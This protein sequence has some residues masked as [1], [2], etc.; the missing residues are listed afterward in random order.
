MQVVQG[1]TSSNQDV[2]AASDKTV[3]SFQQESVFLQIEYE[4]LMERER[5]VQREMEQITN[6][7]E[8][9][10]EQTKGSSPEKMQKL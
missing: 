3:D 8:Q 1:K 5:Q 2:M 6:I 7:I 10:Q 9:M 4:K